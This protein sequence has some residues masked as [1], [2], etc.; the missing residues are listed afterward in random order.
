[1]DINAIV[2]IATVGLVIGAVIW[3]IKQKPPVSIPEPDQ[4][5]KDMPDEYYYPV[6]EVTGVE[7]KEEPKEVILPVVEEP[8]A[9][10]KPVKKAAPKTAKKPTARKP[11]AQ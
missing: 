3:Q 4:A 11:K 6:E 7:I 2:F 9:T 1:M 5:L 8:V 10:K